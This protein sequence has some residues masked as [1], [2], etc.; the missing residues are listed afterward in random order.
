MRVNNFND[1]V[2]LPDGTLTT[3]EELGG[4]DLTPAT[5]ETLGGVKIGSGVN[6]TDDGTISVPEP[7]PYTLPPATSET[8]GGVKIGSGVNVDE[9][10]TISVPA[11]GLT[12]ETFQSNV[13]PKTLDYDGFILCIN[14]ESGTNANVSIAVPGE[15]TVSYTISSGVGPA[16]PVKKNTVVS[17]GNDGGRR[18]TFFYYH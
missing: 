1:P 13:C 2:S 17:I 9:N 10:G 14:H 18:N 7:T 4:D 11:G 15:S 5:S 8:L 12:V 16:V 3:L 6:V